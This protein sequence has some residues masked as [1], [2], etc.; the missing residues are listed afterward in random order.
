MPGLWLD[1]SG[2]RLHQA[3][4]ETQRDRPKPQRDNALRQPGRIRQSSTPCRPCTRN[5][6]TPRQ[7]GRGACTA[8]TLPVLTSNP[9]QSC[10]RMG[11]KWLRTSILRCRCSRVAREAPRK[12][13]HRTMCCSS[14]SAQK[15]PLASTL[16]LMTWSK[17]RPNKPVR[18]NTTKPVRGSRASGRASVTTPWRHSLVLLLLL[19]ICV[20]QGQ[21]P[22]ERLLGIELAHQFLTDLLADVLEAGDFFLSHHDGLNTSSGLEQASAAFVH[23]AHFVTTLALY[24]RTASRTRVCWSAE[25]C[26]HRASESTRPHDVCDRERGSD[27]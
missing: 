5:A 1:Q 19:A 24:L 14:S 8:R 3:Q 2:K 17:P 7:P 26:C 13:S 12:P 6:P 11:R 15:I 4:G 21:H 10:H 18:R 20:P 27:I 16:C 23:T 9:S 25:S 22:I